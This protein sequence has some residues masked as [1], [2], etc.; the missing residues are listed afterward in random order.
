ML[1]HAREQ[2]HHFRREDVSVLDHEQDWVRRGIKEAIYIRALNPAIN[3]DSGHHTLSNHFDKIIKD[4]VAQPPSPTVH[5][6]ETEIAIN[7]APRRQGRPRQ[8]QETL[9]KRQLQQQQP[10][11]QQPQQQPQQPQQQTQGIRRSVRIRLQSATLPPTGAFRGPP[12][13][14]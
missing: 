8:H 2:G 10:Q 6:A 13:A 3:I 11:Q 14:P 1:Q 4:N 12:T 9:P 5:N 7:T